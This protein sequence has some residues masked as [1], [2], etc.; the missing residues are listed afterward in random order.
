MDA[1]IG[2]LAEEPRPPGSKKLRGGEDLY[3]IRV[4]DY[5]AIYRVEDDRRVVL[6][7]DVGNRKDIY[8]P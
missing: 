7:I 2:A 8:G 5:R 6:M 1:A 4:G 3:R